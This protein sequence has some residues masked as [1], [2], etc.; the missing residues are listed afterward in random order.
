MAFLV[1]YCGHFGHLVIWSKSF[2]DCQNPHY[3]Y[4]YLNIYIY[5]EQKTESEI[6]FDHFDFDHFDHVIV[7]HYILVVVLDILYNILIISDIM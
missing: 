4:K 7:A 1:Y 5:S 3:K 2:F 6:H